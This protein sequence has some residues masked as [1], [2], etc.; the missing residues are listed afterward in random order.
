MSKVRS[1][2]RV[3]A[4]ADSVFGEM[5]R[6][7]NLHGAVNLSQGFPDF[8]APA[9]IK[10][11]ACAAISRD[12]NQYAPPY[13]TRELCEAIAGDFSRRHGVPIVADEQVTVCCGSTEAMMAVMLSCLDPGDEVIVFEPFYENYGPDAILSG[14]TPKFVR[15]REPD[16]AFDP[17]ELGAAFSNR[18]RAIVINSPNNPTGKVFSRDELQV[19]AELCQRWDAIAI[20]DEIYEHILFDGR[21]HIPIASLPGMAERTVTTSGLS[22]TFS[23][24]GWRVG[25]A[26]APASLTGGIRKIHDF[27]TVAAP[28]PFQDAGAVALT[29]GDEVYAALAAGYQA[30]RDLL[31]GILER[32]GFTCYQPG[33]AYYLMADVRPFGFAS[34]AEFAHYLIKDIGVATIPGSSF[35]IDPKTAPPTVRFCFSKQDETLRE[36]GRRLAKL[37]CSAEL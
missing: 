1:A 25:W 13:G 7:A 4:F 27:L 11:A 35:Y 24:T 19:I 2:R 17:A 16:W 29:M 28:T 20:S 15:L 12:Q 6:L 37:P 21:A 18:T 31:M 23:V 32:Q 8:E 9:A 34:D 36:A 26:I 33:G 3:S 10:D 30:K 5:T 22:K 14:A